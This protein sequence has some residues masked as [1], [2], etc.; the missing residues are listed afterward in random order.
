[1]SGDRFHELCTCGHS[2]QWHGAEDHEFN[3]ATAARL[4]AATS[5]L[6]EAAEMFEKCCDQSS[7]DRNIIVRRVVDAVRA[8][9]ALLQP[10]TRQEVWTFK[11][12]RA[13]A[14]DQYQVHPG[15]PVRIMEPNVSNAAP[16]W[17]VTKV[18]PQ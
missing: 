15:D 2:R 3:P 9:R 10:E 8:R 18:E 14:G 16:V 11:L 7:I 1:M 12:C 13:Y 5:S 17:V 4:E 6:I